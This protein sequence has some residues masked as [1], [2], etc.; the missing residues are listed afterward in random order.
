[1]RYSGKIG[2]TAQVE[3]APG[4]WDDQITE[5]DYVGDVQQRTETFSQGD[6]VLPRYSATTSVSVLSDGVPKENYSDIAYVTYA[7][8]RWTVSSVVV[9]WPRLVLY[10][11]EEY[12]GPIPAATP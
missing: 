8:V 11:G 1:M 4:V 2:F 12:N 5:V 6:N 3:K 9:Q 7:G 10:I